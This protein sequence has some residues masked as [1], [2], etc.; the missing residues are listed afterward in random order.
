M[1]ASHLPDSARVRVSA[2][3]SNLGPGFDVVGLALDLGLEV[4]ARRAG[5]RA[6]VVHREG[7]A[8]AWPQGEDDLLLQGFERAF[9]ELGGSGGVE[10]AARSEIPVGRGLGSSAA[11]VV[12]GLLLGAHFAP[13]AVPRETLL[14]WA[15][16]LEGHPDNAAPALFGGLQLTCPRAGAPPRAVALELHPELGFALAWPDAQLE[17]AF[18]RT[19]LPR[20]VPLAQASDTARRLA[21][22]LEGLRRGDPELL[23][24]GEVE[25]LHVPHRLPHIQGG[26]QALAAARAAGAHLAT[27]SGSGSALFAVTRRDDAER[28]A[29]AMGEAFRAAGAGGAHRAARVVLTAP[30]VETLDAP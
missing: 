3:T 27:I 22:V 2:S 10:L 23:G 18:A 4:D 21:L 7:E 28:V 6:R 29:R 11:A 26:A 13:R 25:H 1:S 24:A 19:L 17:T 8:R 12:A 30:A 15:I 20:E 5:E 16:E 14:G 9:R